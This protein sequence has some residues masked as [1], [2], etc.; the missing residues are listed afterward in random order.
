MIDRTGQ[1]WQKMMG[2]KDRH[3]YDMIV[4]DST[5]ETRSDGVTLVSGTNHNVVRFYHRRK[6]FEFSTWYEPVGDAWENKMQLKR[7]V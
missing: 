4:L 5:V 6:Q 7:L 2:P 3:T 1:V